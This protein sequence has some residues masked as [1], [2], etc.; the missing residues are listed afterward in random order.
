MITHHRT[1]RPQTRD[2]WWEALK[3]GD[4]WAND[5]EWL[6]SSAWGHLPV[7]HGEGNWSIGYLTVTAE[8]K[9]N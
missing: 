7:Q 1:W 3:E 5:N 8:E 6:L 2:A 4:Q 9:E